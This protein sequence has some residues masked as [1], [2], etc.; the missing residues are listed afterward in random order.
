MLN[1]QGSSMFAATGQCLWGIDV[2]EEEEEVANTDKRCSKW[3]TK[4]SEPI[5]LGIGSL[6]YSLGRRDSGEVF[7]TVL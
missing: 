5:T 2:E 7:Y 4:Y 3:V 6:F 1:P